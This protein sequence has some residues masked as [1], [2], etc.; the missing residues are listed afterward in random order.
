MAIMAMATARK[1]NYSRL[2]NVISLL[3]CF[4][5]ASSAMAGEWQFV[6]SFG[7]EETYTDNVELA[8][9]DQTSSFVSQAILALNMDYQSRL[10]N[11]SFTGENNN[12]F[13]SHDSEIDDSYLT[14]DT[15][16]Q[17]YL[18]NNGPALFA[19]AQVGNSNRNA[20]SN[21]LAD[22]VSGDTVQ[23][24]SY[25]TGILYNVQNNTVNIA[26]SLDYT[27]SRFEDG[28]G[29]YDNISAFLN[30]QSGNNARLAFW[31]LSSSYSEREQESLGATRS[32]KQYSID[33]ILGLLTPWKINPFVRFYDEDISGS[34]GIQ[35]QPTTSSW[36]P[37]LRWLISQHLLIDVSYNYVTDDTVSDDYVAASLQWEPSA[38]T[39]ITA[40]YSQ[41]FFGDSY[42][43]DIKHQTKRLTNTITYDESLEVFDRSTFERIDLGQ[44]WCPA[45]TSIDGISDCFAQSTEINSDGYFPQNFFYFEPI[46]SN[47]FTLNKS[48]SWVST[49]QLARTSFTFNSSASRRERIES[50]IINDTLSASLS[51]NR[52]ISG[53]SNLTLLAKYNYRIF[54]KDNTDD[55]GQ[56]DHYRTVSATYTKDLASSLSTNFTVQHVNRSSN[57]EQ[58]TYNELRAIIN[59]KKEF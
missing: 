14:L 32:G 11:F 34:F 10:A 17:L 55:R 59:I 48:F 19:T 20:A 6:P 7:I 16:G 28:I 24:T 42:N 47:E 26:S 46:E 8:N 50:Q 58:Y 2:A 5:F 12:L 30:T 13:Y 49:L 45:N 18:W 39:S 51:I 44:F 1:I 21:G 36:G 33:A 3:S 38:R 31:Q 43:L 27:I 52:K 25:S 37:G 9:T 54:D 57:L 23:S 41:R 22:L 40:G 4:T 56:K 35:N 29:E 15:E 53:K